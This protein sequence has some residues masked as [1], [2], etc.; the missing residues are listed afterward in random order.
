[1]LQHKNVNDEN[2]FLVCLRH[3]PLQWKIR[4]FS[5]RHTYWYRHQTEVRVRGQ[6][7][8]VSKHH[9]HVIQHITYY[10][11]HITWAWPLF[12][13]GPRLRFI[14]GR[15]AQRNIQC[16]ILFSSLQID[17]RKKRKKMNEILIVTAIKF[18]KDTNNLSI[19]I[20][21]ILFV[22]SWRACFCDRTYRYDMKCIHRA[23]WC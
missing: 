15:E 3:F 23:I 6:I 4:I 8:K 13:K 17:E 14:N 16:H 11:L 10:I 22:Y 5:K 1:M 19:G 18:T 2:P 9:G 12:M 7:V 20:Y 21:Q